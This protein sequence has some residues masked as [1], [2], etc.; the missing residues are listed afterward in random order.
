MLY[1]EVNINN[2]IHDVDTNELWSADS[3][4]YD[5]FGA[6]LTDNQIVVAVPELPWLQVVYSED[7][8]S[9]V[10]FKLSVDWDKADWVKVKA[11]KS[12]AVELTQ[13][14]VVTEA[15]KSATVVADQDAERTNE[16]TAFLRGLAKNNGM[17]TKASRSSK[18]PMSKYRLWMQ[19]DMLFKEAVEEVGQVIIDNV[20]S[21]LV[22]EATEGDVN[23]IKYFLDARATERGYGKGDKVAETLDHELDLTQLELSEQQELARLLEKCQPK[24]IE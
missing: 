1:D 10:Y 18:V 7:Y 14:S 13:S 5:L 2:I 12:K 6:F 17:L 23:A 21:A 3:R 4:A 24:L 20:E 19:T 11:M 8:P 22:D 9:E 16:Q 15:V